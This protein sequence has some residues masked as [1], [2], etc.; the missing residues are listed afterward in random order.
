MFKEKF[1]DSKKQ[2]AYHTGIKIKAKEQ[3]YG[4]RKGYQA[5][6]FLCGSEVEVNRWTN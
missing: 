4:I 1:M 5:F 2:I 6:M 3:L